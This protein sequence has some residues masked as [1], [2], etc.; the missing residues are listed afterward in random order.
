[1]NKR[2]KQFISLYSL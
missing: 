1:M 2:N